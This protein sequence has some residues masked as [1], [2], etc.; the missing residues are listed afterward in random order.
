MSTLQTQEPIL[1]DSTHRYVLFPIQMNDVWSMY[2]KAISAFWT[3]EEIDFSRD[4]DDWNNKLND[5]ERHFIKHVLAFFAGSDGIV[6]ENLAVRFLKEITIPEIR[7]FY[8]F[9][10]FNEGQH[11]EMYSLLIDTY[12]KDAAEKT[13]LLEAIETIPA[14]QKKAHWAMK[15]IDGI[16]SDASFAQRLLAFVIVEGIFFSGSFC[17][18]YWLKNRGLMPGLTFSNELISKDEGL[19]CEFAILLYSK[20]VNR[21]SQETVHQMFQEAITI[22]K[23][24]I[25]ESLPVELIGMNSTLMKEYIEYVSDRLLKQLHYDPLFGTKNPFDF[26]EM[27]SLRPKANFFEIRVGEYQ[28]TGVGKKEE[29]KDI[30]T[31]SDD[32]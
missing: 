9:Q 5:Q 18:I 12:V 25:T 13:H 16:Q 26:M 21:L 24:F 23:E 10:I 4:H 17:S 32:F 29:E 2:K 7:H 1:Q 15:W 27:I 20:L 30:F 31:V 22:E 28:K 3:P 14:V 11:S 8:S 6:M 19:H